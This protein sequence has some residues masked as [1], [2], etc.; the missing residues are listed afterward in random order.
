LKSRVK[1]RK[2]S[3]RVQI[4]RVTE[5]VVKYAVVVSEIFELAI[6]TAL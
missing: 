4:E 1:V 5:Y 2:G 6:E 3:E